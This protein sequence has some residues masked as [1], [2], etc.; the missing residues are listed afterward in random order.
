LNSSINSLLTIDRIGKGFI[1]LM[2]G[3]TKAYL[4]LALAWIDDKSVE[5]VADVFVNQEKRTKRKRN[6]YKARVF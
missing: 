1:K 3:T 2:T 5:A 4:E 6:F